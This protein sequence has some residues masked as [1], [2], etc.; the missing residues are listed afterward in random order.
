MTSAIAILA[1]YSVLGI[2]TP[3]VV[4]GLGLDTL[5]AWLEWLL[6]GL[7]VLGL[8]AVLAYILWYA[9]TLNDPVSSNSPVKD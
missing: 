9:K 6:V 2:V 4:M 8:S 3:V 7:F 5:A 1:I